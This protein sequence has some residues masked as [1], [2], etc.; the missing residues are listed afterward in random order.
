MMALR[1]IFLDVF[2][3]AAPASKEVLYCET[4]F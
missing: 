3:N 4:A 2:S 1:F